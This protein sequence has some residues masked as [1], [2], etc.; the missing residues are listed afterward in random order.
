MKAILQQLRGYI[1][2]LK[3]LPSAAALLFMAAMVF[4]NY[5]FSLN[6]R[7]HSLNEWA[8]YFSWLL[9]LALV[10][11]FYP[12]LLKLKG[13]GKPL[14]PVFILG[15]IL[16]AWKMSFDF[17]LPL[18]SAP[19]VNKFYNTIIYWPFKLLVVFL[20][21]KL[22]HSFFQ[23]DKPFYGTQKV[24]FSLLPYFLMVALMLPFILLAASTPEFQ[25][26]YPKFMK[27][28]LP[29]E[30][31]GFYMLLFELAYGSDFLTIELFFRG[32]LILALA[33]S[34]GKE[35]ILPMALFY[36]TIHFGKP[37]GECISSFFGGILLGVVTY[38][39]RSIWGGLI[40][41]L[42]IAWAMEFAGWYLR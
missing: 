41:H 4:L 38:H 13:E 36:C 7:I 30:G 16:F 35:A 25:Q 24:Q 42:G 31:T 20:L 15:P 27:H 2:S 11:N 21:L 22:Y 34:Y 14:H 32:F 39:T 8:Q 40:V 23:K 33:S 5:H 29:S 1:L 12:L 26:V 10:Y 17:I 6:K 3:P 9:I 18:S 37:L 19:S 28:T